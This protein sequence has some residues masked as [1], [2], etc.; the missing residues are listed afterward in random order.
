MYLIDL[1]MAQSFT[2]LNVDILGVQWAEMVQF[3]LSK[4]ML[5]SFY[6]H[7]F[8]CPSFSA[9]QD[10]VTLVLSSQIHQRFGNPNGIL[11]TPINLTFVALNQV[12]L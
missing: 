10:P 8:L 5:V 1:F 11:A 7:F 4:N 3:G 6:N 2:Y 9:T 12:H